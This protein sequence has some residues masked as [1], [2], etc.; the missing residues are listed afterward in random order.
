MRLKPQKDP[1]I[2]TKIH[3]HTWCWEIRKEKIGLIYGWESN[4]YNES[5]LVA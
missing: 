2:K 3:R 5:C 1:M 4:M